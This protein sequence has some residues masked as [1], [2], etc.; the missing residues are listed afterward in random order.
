MNIIKKYILNIFYKN[1]DDNTDINLFFDNRFNFIYL[2]LQTIKLSKQKSSI[3][4]F[5]DCLAEQIKFYSYNEENFDKWKLLIKLYNY[6]LQKKLFQEILFENEDDNI[7]INDRIKNQFYIIFQPVKYFGIHYD[8][9]NEDEISEEF[10]NKEIYKY[11]IKKYNKRVNSNIILKIYTELLNTI[12]SPKLQNSKYNLNEFHYIINK[13]NIFFSTNN[14]K[15]KDDDTQNIFNILLDYLN[16]DSYNLD[17]NE[18]NK[19]ENKRRI[20]SN[21]NRII[22]FDLI[23]DIY[24]SKSN[25]D[26]YNLIPTILFPLLSIFNDAY[27]KDNSLNIMN[28]QILSF[29]PTIGD[30]DNNLFGYFFDSILFYEDYNEKNYNIENNKAE[31]LKK[32]ID[33][34]ILSFELYTKKYII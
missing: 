24:N 10:I 11:F 12:L 16:K 34:K 8:Y 1:N 33:S 23:K 17:D 20:R 18:I 14:G 21:N 27:E 32:L 30:E 9:H 25:I 7:D 6:L 26:K 3:L 13:E 28:K 2:T 4:F 29:L 19:I 15:N 5:L 22:L 31:E